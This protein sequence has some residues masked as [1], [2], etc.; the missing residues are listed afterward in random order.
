M[1]GN[2]YLWEVIAPK[3]YGLKAIW[4]NRGN[5]GIKNNENIKQIML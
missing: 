3:Q 4:V 1:I 2:H 5:L